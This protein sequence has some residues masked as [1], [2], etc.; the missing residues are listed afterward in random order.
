MENQMKSIF[1]IPTLVLAT[2]ACSFATT[3]A[4]A[5]APPKAAEAQA[6]N[7]EVKKVQPHSHSQEK[8]GMMP[9]KKPSKAKPAEEKA[10]PAVAT[11]D[12]PADSTKSKSSSGKK[13]RADKDKSRHYHPRDGK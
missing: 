7:A 5:N 1:T 9:Q 13:L 4:A 10:D 11:E 8:T 2:A 3:A 6:D 12:I